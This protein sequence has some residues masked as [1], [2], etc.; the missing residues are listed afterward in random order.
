MEKLLADDI[1]TLSVSHMQTALSNSQSDTTSFALGRP[2]KNLLPLDEIKDSIASL[3]SP[4][5]LQYQPPIKKLKNHIKQIMSMKNIECE[6]NQII[7]TSGAQQA[8]TLLSRL[9]LNKGDEVFVDEVSYPGFIQI[10]K[11]YSANLHEVPWV[12]NQGPNLKALES[13]LSIKKKCKFF[14]TIPDGHNPI[15]QNITANCRKTCIDFSTKHGL[16]ILEDDAYGFLNYDNSLSVPMIYYNPQHVIYIGTFSK[17][18]APSMRVGWVVAPSYIIQKLE[19]LKES[20]DINTSTFSQHVLSSTLERISI[21]QHLKLIN[22]IYKEKR[23]IMVNSIKKYVPSMIF[24]IPSNG[25]FIW[26][27]IPGINTD[28]LFEIATKHFKV[29][30]IPGNACSISKTH[31]NYLR[32]SFSYCTASEIEDGIKR[33]SKAMQFCLKNNQ[34]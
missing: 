3:S 16:P 5:C 28:K 24:N 25:F 26:G 9:F 34:K 22:K 27:K 12:E 19:I 23:D 7:I 20:N 8:M 15:G 10:A 31:Q 11:S 6:D 21:F 30:F 2:D 17:I 32:L 4:N 18:F 14:Y 29:S 13:V 1:K 33:L